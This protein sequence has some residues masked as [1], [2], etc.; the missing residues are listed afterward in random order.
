[1]LAASGR[2]PRSVGEARVFG[3]L[4]AVPWLWGCYVWLRACLLKLRRR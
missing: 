3:V 1:M 4:L 2:G